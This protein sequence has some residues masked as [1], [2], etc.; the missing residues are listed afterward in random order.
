MNECSLAIQQLEFLKHNRLET[1]FI[2]VSEIEYLRVCNL[3]YNIDYL[4]PPLILRHYL[5][6]V[7]QK[8][9]NL[10]PTLLP[11]LFIFNAVLTQSL[12]LLC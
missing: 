9:L 10:D 12:A 5:I 2:C 7:V 6:V 11:R 3:P 4:S 1:I 8:V